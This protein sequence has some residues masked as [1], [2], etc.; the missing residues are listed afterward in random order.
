M[1]GFCAQVS[2]LSTVL[3]NAL[4][5]GNGT[6]TL[7]EEYSDLHA[8]RHA[9]YR[10]RAPCSATNPAPLWALQVAGAAQLPLSLPR[11][12]LLI[13]LQSAVPYWLE[14]ERCGLRRLCFSTAKS[15]R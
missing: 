10:R 5:T 9:L 2:L 15:K 3:Y 14:R 13:A 7:G 6:P 4:T 11:R 8:V 1:C 12:A